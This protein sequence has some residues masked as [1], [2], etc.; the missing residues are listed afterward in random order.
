MLIDPYN[1]MPAIQAG[2]RKAMRQSTIGNVEVCSYRE[3][4]RRDH[5]IGYSSSDARCLGTGYHAGLETWWEARKN[6]TDVTAEQIEEAIRLAIV[7]DVTKSED[8]FVWVKFHNIDEMV[9]K[10]VEMVGIYLAHHVQR[11]DGYSVIGTEISF[12]MPYGDRFAAIGTIDLVIAD[13]LGNPIIIDHKTAGK[14]WA[15]KKHLTSPQPGWYSYWWVEAAKAMGVERMPIPKMAFEIMTYAGKFDRRWVIPTRRLQ[16]AT[17]EKADVACRLLEDDGP[18][19]P[20]TSS[21]L[22]SDKYCDHFDAC[23]HGGQLVSIQQEAERLF[24][25]EEKKEV[26]Q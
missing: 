11:W 16:Q 6:G 26:T 25:E 18:W 8:R 4:M 2:E 9:A 19:W 13:R 17:L 3:K 23:A 7:D 15:Y 1:M 20:N 14:M 12:A 10:A 24:K 21:N 5:P 22:C